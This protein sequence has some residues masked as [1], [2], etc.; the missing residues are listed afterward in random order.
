[1]ESEKEAGS[2]GEDED[3]EVCETARKSFVEYR[4]YFYVVHDAF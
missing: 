2:D 4:F 1:M 3:D